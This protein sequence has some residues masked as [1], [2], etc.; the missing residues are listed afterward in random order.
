MGSTHLP[1][2]TLGITL[3]DVGRVGG[4]RDRSCRHATQ[5]KGCLLCV[6]QALS[7]LPLVRASI[8]DSLRRS[9]R[10]PGPLAMAALVLGPCV[11]ICLAVFSAADGILFRPLPYTDPDRLF[12]LQQ[13]NSGTGRATATISAQQFDAVSRSVAVTGATAFWAIGDSTI[14]ETESQA[15]L[16]HYAH[17]D[18]EFCHVLG[19]LPLRGR[20]PNEHE[21]RAGV[22]VA[23]LS[24]RAASTTF[25]DPLD[26]VGRRFRANARTFEVVGVLNDDVVVPSF[27]GEQPDILFPFSDRA[28][29]PTP[30]SRV[31]AV[32]RATSGVTG[33]E[34]QARVMG[35]LHEQGLLEDAASVIR[36]EPVHR[37]LFELRR[38]AVWAFLVGAALVLLA[39]AINIGL[40]LTD[41]LMSR[42]AELAMR[43][44]LGMPP[45]GALLSAMVD[46]V[47]LALSAAAASLAAFWLLQDWLASWLPAGPVATMWQGVSWRTVVAGLIAAGA[48]AA[49]ACVTALPELRRA[50]VEPHVLRWGP[51][52][53]RRRSGSMIAVQVAVGVTITAVAF[54]L[55]QAL[56]LQNPASLG[57]GRS[58][59]LVVKAFSAAPQYR[60]ADGPFRLQ[61]YV[62]E[63][64]RATP[65]V[66][67]AGASSSVPGARTAPERELP[68]GSS[69]P[70]AVVHRASPGYFTAIGSLLRGR[71][72]A[73]HDSSDGGAVLVNRSFAAGVWPGHSALGQQV[74]LSPEG[75]SHE[76]VG[77]VDDL[78][79]G[80]GMPTLPA[81]YLPLAPAAARGQV[82]VARS[83]A[84]D[85][86][87]AA[88]AVA[89]ALQVAHP[90]V[91]AR[92]LTLD[93]HLE[94]AL[95]EQR[96]RARL[97]GSMGSLAL[98][99]CL[100]SLLFTT[101]RGIAQRWHEMAVRLC[102][103]A[104]LRS[105]RRQLL[106]EQALSFA[107]GL[108]GGGVLSAMYL[109]G[110]RDV[111]DAPSQAV[112]PICAAGV[113]FLTSM[114][115]IVLVAMRRLRRLHV[116][117]L[118]RL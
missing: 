46:A 3:S 101:W 82:I 89:A 81:V 56:S 92:V 70:G 55:W 60:V 113:L 111:Q 49:V 64:V 52:G 51:P 12:L 7:I 18:S 77:L 94:V 45:A 38:R 6:S 39:G 76:V 106:Q 15:Q 67:A 107:I 48:A 11:G 116:Q 31:M 19:L 109:I 8:A 43:L 74:T 24:H 79:A 20:C 84:S 54:S 30:G 75:P 40:L 23:V 112:I 98:V 99:L 93:E 2:G 62:L 61:V 21:L 102:C 90:S 110:L 34:L 22:P 91:A 13:L 71:D 26:S 36:V 95:S 63:T 83:S 96:F 16:L 80:F 42:R 104:T 105:L 57:L 115:T 118:L 17:V 37:A 65:G 88:H 87:S 86:S 29:P 44:V 66:A 27:V 100:A 47:M 5:R 78:R 4:C 85:L 50:S 14:V 1:P 33:G 114:L 9:A 35:L 108:G 103:G 69:L 41:T 25:G 59:V 53:H 32:V 73:P 117:D 72:L 58:D 97:F 68:L 10:R 28:A